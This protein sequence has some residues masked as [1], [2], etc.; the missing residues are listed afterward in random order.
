LREGYVNVSVPG[1]EA[2]TTEPLRIEMK[3]ARVLSG[4]VVGPEGEPVAGASVELIEERRTGRGGR[5]LSVQSLGSTDM[6]GRFRVSGPPPG[7]IILG[8][9][10]EG[11]APHRIEGLQIPEDRDLEDVRI[12]LA[13]G[14]ILDVRVLAAEGDPVANISVHVSSAEEAGEEGER[15]ASMSPGSSSRCRTDLAGRC[16]LTVG[17]PGTYTVEAS[18]SGSAVSALVKAVPGGTPVELRFPSGSEISGRVIGEDGAGIAGAGVSLQ[19]ETGRFSL[20]IGAGLDGTFV[21]PLIPDGNYRLTADWED[22]VT[23]PRVLSVAGRSLRGLELRLNQKKEEKGRESLTGRLLG[24]TPEELRGTT[25]GI[26]SLSGGFYAAE[27]DREG[28]YRFERLEPGEW[29]VQA[30]TSDGRQAQGSVQILPGAGETTLD[31]EFQ[32]GFTLAGRVLLDGKPLPGGDVQAWG[33]E[34]SVAYTRTAHDGSFKLAGLTAGMATLVVMGSQGFAGTQAFQVTEDQEVSIALSTG[35][36][37][38]QVLA[39]TGEPV[40]DATVVLDAW[41]AELGT[42]ISAPGARTG[43]D[44]SFEIPRLGTG[45]YKIKVLKEGFVTTEA[46]A[47]VT[48]GGGGPPVEILLK[49]RKGPS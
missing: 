13:R 37:S 41:I 23:E 4:Q 30:G 28:M 2:P 33:M 39:A 7:S 29:T 3:V 36:L 8:I 40:E 26:V 12:A 38:G 22:L 14:S 1:V 44:G 34:R 10:A 45:T 15:L 6:E 32:K 31:L 21:F 24:L 25:L 16:R 5:S 9:R 43:A 20:G 42:S 27:P 47:E 17:K 48:T 18:R 11:Y 46:T 35:R 19:E 49:P